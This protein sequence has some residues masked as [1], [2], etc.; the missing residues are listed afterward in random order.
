MLRDVPAGFAHKNESLAVLTTDLFNW[1]YAYQYPSDCLKINRLQL[2]YEAVTS[3]T[4]SG[5]SAFNLSLPDLSR[6]INYE[7]FNV[8]G[9]KVIGA[10]ESEL[11]IDYRANVTDQNL[12][13][14]DF[15]LA[16]AHLLASELATPLVGGELGRKY[17]DDEL[18]LYQV[19]VD[20]TI[21][22]TLN[23]RYHNRPESEYLSTRR[24]G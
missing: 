18:K 3:E 12:F 10:N 22:A 13:D 21:V 5:V 1:A 9:V 7:V 19:Y 2:N 20:A 6:Q 16:F 8:D 11:R 24:S 4:L 17:R 14:P 15:I 23:E